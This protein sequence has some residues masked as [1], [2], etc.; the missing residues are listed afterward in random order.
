[1]YLIV[2]RRITYALLKTRLYGCTR[3]AEQMSRVVSDRHGRSFTI[4]DYVNKGSF[5]KVY[6]LVC[7]LTK[8]TFAG[9][10][11][12]KSK[13]HKC[14][15]GD[16]IFDEI[17]IHQM[18]RHK[19]IVQFLT[20]IEEG[21]YI[22]IV[23]E[24]C[25]KYSMLNVLHDLKTLTVAASKYFMIQTVSAVKYLHGRRVVHRDLKLGNLFVNDRMELKLGDFGLAVVIKYEG[26]KRFSRC[27]TPN[28][29]APE[30]ISGVGHSYEVDVWALGCILY[31]MLEGTPPFQGQNTASTYNNILKGHV[32]FS[33]VIDESAK[34]FVTSSL[35]ID[36]KLRPSVFGLVNFSFL[37]AKDPY[38]QPPQL[39][40][41][42]TTSHR[43]AHERNASTLPTVVTIGT[44]QRRNSNL[45]FEKL[46]NCLA[47]V[48]EWVLY[49]LGE[50]LSEHVAIKPVIWV[51]SWMDYTN[52]YGFTYRL[53]NKTV[54]VMF[55]DR[56]RM[57]MNETRTVRYVERN[58]ASLVCRSENAPNYLRN[59]IKILTK[60]GQYMSESLSKAHNGSS[61]VC[62]SGDN[63]TAEVIHWTR[64][65]REM[66]MFL[67][68][69]SVQVNFARDHTK[70]ILCGTSKTL[71]VIERADCMKTFKIDGLNKFGCS[72][73]MKTKLTTVLSC[74]QRFLKGDDY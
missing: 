2:I 41:S 40:T 20:Y 30:V 21:K 27:G 10:F 19:N 24:Y 56:T 47:N 16:K 9:K 7:C 71:T 67:N 12:S 58:G 35:Q 4:G 72:V 46:A 42:D 15:F 45:R 70:Y 62:R 23:L 29:L 53:N 61:V 44:D 22:I 69:G 13:L 33:R 54:G 60:C 65:D 52:S 25:S 49:D 66:V 68:N 38:P 51:N 31:T 55:N 14:G 6:T 18:L 59:K 8:Q 3:E 5:S 48:P 28:Y 73:T 39:N 36:P 63:L 1:M 57:I 43:T 50:F 11:I 34:L 64:S 37:V 74:I 26:Q 32:H 17:N